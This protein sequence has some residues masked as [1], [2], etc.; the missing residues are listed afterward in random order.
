M[1]SE[2]FKISD[3]L[4]E[5]NNKLD[6]NEIGKYAIEIAKEYFRSKD[7][8]AQ[9]EIP[10]KGEDLIVKSKNESKLY[11]IKGSKMP[12]FRFKQ[13][14]ISGQSS[15]EKIESKEAILMRIVNIGKQDVTICF[16]EYDK[17][18]ILEKV[19]RWIIKKKK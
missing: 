12:E 16:L 17:D 3:K 4:L 8:D 7:I 6:S 18:F 11:E 13:L 10:R 2:P 19:P 5:D 14:Y 9:F 15:F 1:K